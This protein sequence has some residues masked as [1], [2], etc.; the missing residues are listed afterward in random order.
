MNEVKIFNLLI[1]WMGCPRE[2]MLKPK[3][4]FFFLDYFSF[5]RSLLCIFS[6]ASKLLD[7]CLVVYLVMCVARCAVIILIY[8]DIKMYRSD[9]QINKVK[10]SHP[11][12][13]LFRPLWQ[14][15]LNKN[16]VESVL[17]KQTLK[18]SSTW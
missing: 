18:Y 4:H 11:I 7:V 12:R 15:R 5:N 14:L 16:E 13:S 6:L 2:I 8:F 10:K 3:Q 9:I 1:R 17:A